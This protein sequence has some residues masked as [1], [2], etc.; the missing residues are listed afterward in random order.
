MPAYVTNMPYLEDFPRISYSEI[1]ALQRC[2]QQHDYAYRQGLVPKE[3]PEYFTKGRYLH[4]LLAAWLG[5]AADMSKVINRAAQLMTEGRRD[6]EP[7]VAVVAQDVAD[8]L[9]HRVQDF[10]TR[11]DMTGVEVLAVEREFYADLGLPD[12]TMLHGFIDAVL[13]TDEGIWI[14]EHKTAGRAWSRG[15]F[16]FD[17]QPKLYAAAWRAVSGEAPV[18]VVYNFFYPKRWE[19]KQVYLPEHE[20]DLAVKE[21]V[22]AVD[23]RAEHLAMRSPHW[24]CNDCA[25]FK[26]LCHAELIGEDTTYL[27]Q[28]KFNV[29]PEKVGRFQDS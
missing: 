1:R 29:D 19:Q 10:I 8:E 11:T 26:V 23:L 14:V 7:D 3:T 16:A 25:M 2:T 6:S 27:R 28:T 5:G 18:G 12:Q 4:A 15:Q 21:A 9:H 17:L 22:K 20:V 13:R 24:G